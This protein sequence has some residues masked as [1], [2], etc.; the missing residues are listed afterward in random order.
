[1]TAGIAILLSRLELAVS[2]L[3]K[4]KTVAVLV[5]FLVFV[6]IDIAFVMRTQVKTLK[7]L[8][9]EIVKIKKD[10]SGLSKELANLKE[11]KSKQSQ[12]Q[13][14]MAKIKEII[15]EDQWSALLQDV[16]ALA[17]QNNVKI[18]QIGAA[19]ET[20]KTQRV[21]EAAAKDAAKKA[22][23]KFATRSLTLDLFCDY[24]TLG[25]YIDD[26]ENDRKFLAVEEMRIINNANDYFHQDVKLVLQTYVKK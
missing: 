7:P 19:K 25:A 18:L 21:P 9:K 5:A 16:S 22:P 14:N 23:A 15:P 10:I 20:K 8:G 2:K 1:M 11:L 17:N 6:Y 3:D 13:Q 24:H 4:K 26:L 12:V